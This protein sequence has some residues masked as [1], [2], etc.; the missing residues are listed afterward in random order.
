MS[1]TVRSRS[2]SENDS[3][4][5]R[6]NATAWHTRDSLSDRAWEGIIFHVFFFF[7]NN[8]YCVNP[9]NRLYTSEYVRVAAQV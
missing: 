5:R 1:S 4:T 9:V 3:D 7:Y 2:S 8:L 6:N